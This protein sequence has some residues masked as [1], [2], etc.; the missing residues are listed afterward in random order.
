MS[1]MILIPI[2]ESGGD[3]FASRMP[4]TSVVAVQPFANLGQT[5]G[6]I[7]REEAERLPPLDANKP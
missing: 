4:L 2:R 6:S 7:K 1:E 3:P 5:G